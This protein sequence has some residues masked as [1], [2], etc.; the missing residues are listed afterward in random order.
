MRGSAFL[1]RIFCLMPVRKLIVQHGPRCTTLAVPSLYQHSLSRFFEDRGVAL[2]IRKGSRGTQYCS[3]KACCTSRVARELF[4][5]WAETVENEFPE[6]ADEPVAF[7]KTEPSRRY[8][9]VSSSNQA[10]GPLEL[11]DINELVRRQIITEDTLVAVEGENS[12]KP[13]RQTPELAEL[14]MATGESENNTSEIDQVRALKTIEKVDESAR[15]PLPFSKVIT[16][17]AKT[18][19][20]AKK[21]IWQRLQK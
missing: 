20:L 15:I 19:T 13:F 2:M 14:T 5:D 17:F 8:Y 1:R 9:Y 10:E 16:E 3:L 12:W 4:A 11:I 18:S 7:E 21:S 6:A